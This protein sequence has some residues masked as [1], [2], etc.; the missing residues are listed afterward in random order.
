MQL[1]LQEE[2]YDAECWNRFLS[3]DDEAFVK[4]YMN[5]IDAMMNYGLHFTPMRDQVKD[6]I[7]D[8]FT[9]IYSKRNRL[10]AV[11][12]VRVY[13]FVAL[14]NEL[15]ARF[16][17]D[18]KLYQIDTIEPVFNIDTSV[19]DKYIM[20]EQNQ[21][22]KRDI[23]QMLQSLS[24]RQREVIYYRFSQEMSF[25]EICTLMQMNVQSVR[26]LLYRSIQKIKET[27]VKYG[28]EIHS[29]RT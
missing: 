29:K 14:K 6:A 3:G 17:K 20:N 19:E 7:Q 8:V 24:P 15:F 1:N 5:H 22:L 10:K 28:K 21:A 4:L 16:N 9:N 2:H 26:N 18:E 27:Y 12:N 25:D 13:L 23:Q 11:D